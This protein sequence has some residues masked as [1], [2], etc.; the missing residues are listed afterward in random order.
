MKKLRSKLTYANVMATIAVF[1]ALGG[2]SYAATQLPK[3][4]VGPKQLK[5]N[6]V[7]TAKIKDGAVTTA[8]IGN[9]AVTGA[10][11]DSGSL[12]TVPSA[13]HATSAD[14]AKSAST[15]NSA[16]N[17]G[18]LGGVAAGQYVTAQSVLA[19]KATETGVFG[20]N[21]TGTGGWL[22]AAINFIPKAP[23]ALDG[24]HTIYV[25][26]SPGSATHCPGIGQA[27]PG[28]LC[29][30]GKGESSVSFLGFYSPDSSGEAG[31]TKDGTTVYFTPTAS[32]GA[33]IRG[34]WAY[35]A[36]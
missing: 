7:T 11:I 6:A 33:Y 12:G 20:G 31:A 8:K 18:A 36:P 23:S 25:P 15:A 22:V 28:Y 5:S 21:A 10:K 4:S 34:V 16:Q 24:G 9:G 35:T 1:I 2:A 27:D 17:A 3:N 26:Q 14:S 30:Y 13:A 19:S 32:E 29:A